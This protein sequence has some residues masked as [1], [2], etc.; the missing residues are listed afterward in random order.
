MSAL[1]DFLNLFADPA[2]VRAE[3]D[4]AAQIQTA[5]GLKEL[6]GGTLQPFEQDLFP[7]EQPTPGLQTGRPGVLPQG[8]QTDFITQLLGSKNPQLIQQGVGLAGQGLN[9]QRQMDIAGAARQTLAPVFE[10]LRAQENV[11]PSI[12]FLSRIA[13]S[14]SPYA[15]KAFEELAKTLQPTTLS[16]GQTR[17]GAFGQAIATGGVDPTKKQTAETGLRKEYNQLTKN[18]RESD[19]A[20]AKIKALGT[21]SQHTPATDNSLLFQYARLLSPGIVT[22]EDFENAKRSG[23][24]GWAGQIRTFANQL[25]NGM[26]P[27]AVRQNIVNASAVQFAGESE[28]FKGVKDDYTN[29]AKQ[30]NLDPNNVVGAS[31]IRTDISDLLNTGVTPQVQKVGRFTMKVKK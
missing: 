6:I 21:V 23:T 2:A 22:S 7:G 20:M 18:I 14:G 12:D 29:L 10:K 31:R 5:Q 16:P 13:E 11:S 15:N 17:V 3:Q 30:N 27:D 25:Q 24:E 28:I 19:E 9:A 1:D 8:P 4:R 26:L